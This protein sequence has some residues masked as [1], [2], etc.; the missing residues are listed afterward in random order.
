MGKHIKQTDLNE[1]R[2]KEKNKINPELADAFEA[3]IAHQ[4]EILALKAEIQALK[5][6]NNK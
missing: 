1:L 5:G 2:I 4:E 3:I 6:E